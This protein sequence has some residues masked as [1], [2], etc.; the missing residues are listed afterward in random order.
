[1]PSKQKGIAHW[2]YIEQ[3]ITFAPGVE[4]GR[5]KLGSTVILLFPEGKMQWNKELQREVLIKMG[6]SL[7]VGL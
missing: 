2:N 1:M 3:E 6:Q 5:F 7:G 4:I